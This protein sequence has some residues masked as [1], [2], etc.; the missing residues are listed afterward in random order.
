MPIATVACV[1]VLEMVDSRGAGAITLAS[2]LCDG[3]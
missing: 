3:L 2:A 1:W